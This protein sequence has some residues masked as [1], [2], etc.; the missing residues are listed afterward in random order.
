MHQYEV[1]FILGGKNES[2]IKTGKYYQYHQQLC[3]QI[4]KRNCGVS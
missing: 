2:N 3:N 4:M 1:S